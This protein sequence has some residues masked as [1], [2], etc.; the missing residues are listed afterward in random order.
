VRDRKK[1]SETM[2]TPYWRPLEVE[3]EFNTEVVTMPTPYWRP[4]EVE[5]EFNTEVV[6]MP[7]PF[8]RPLEVEVEFNTEVV[9]CIILVLLKRIDGLSHHLNIIV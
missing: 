8:W 7:T 5:V 1:Y 4:L 9:I 3:V 6:A 2:P